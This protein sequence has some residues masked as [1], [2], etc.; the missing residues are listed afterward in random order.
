M[1]EEQVQA[2]VQKIESNLSMFQA[3]LKRHVRELYGI[4]VTKAAVSR[5]LK[6]A[7]TKAVKRNTDLANTK[8]SPGRRFLEELRALRSSSPQ[9]LLSIVEA[10]IHLNSAPRFAWAPRESELL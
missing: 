10:P 6:R 7:A 4:T 3:D 5:N 9:T 1:S 8:S 2:L